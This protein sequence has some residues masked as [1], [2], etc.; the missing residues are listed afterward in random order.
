MKNLLLLPISLFIFGC[1]TTPP[2]SQWA[3]R[4]PP[5]IN[6]LD[7]LEML[8]HHEGN[9]ET[10]TRDLASSQEDLHLGMLK[11]SVQSFLG[12]PDQIE[13][14]GNPIYGNERWTYVRSV[15]T[16]DGYYTEKRVIYF[17]RGNVVGWETH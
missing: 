6:D 1:M 8:L 2:N 14:A 13:V 15:P 16:M 12:R 10:S 5:A 11:N 17:E 7:S 3:R 4:T 9:V